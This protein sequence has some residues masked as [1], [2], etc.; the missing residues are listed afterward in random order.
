[1]VTSAETL[2][3]FQCSAHLDLLRIWI[4]SVCTPSTLCAPPPLT[5]NVPLH[6]K[7]LCKNMARASGG[8][9]SMR[10][11]SW[12]AQTEEIRAFLTFTLL[13]R[14]SFGVSLTA[15]GRTSAVVR[16]L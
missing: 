15:E 6:S 4:F 11:L 10:P 3:T 8:A 5:E 2:G 14:I 7:P 1:M 9:K 16:K 12:G 13:S